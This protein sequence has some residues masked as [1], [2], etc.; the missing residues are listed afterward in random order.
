MNAFAQNYAKYLA[1][2]DKFNHNPNKG[3]LGECLYYN[4]SF[5]RDVG[6]NSALFWYSEINED[7]GFNFDANEDDMYNS[8]EYLKMLLKLFF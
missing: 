3:S 4:P 1:K 7:G 6:K 5:D 8:C 2:N